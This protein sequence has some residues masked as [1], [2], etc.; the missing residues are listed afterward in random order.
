MPQSK[1]KNQ[2]LTN[3]LRTLTLLLLTAIALLWPS[4]TA[5]A[6]TLNWQLTQ[7]L[8]DMDAYYVPPFT[9]PVQY[10][11]TFNA[12]QP[13]PAAH[14][15]RLNIDY[16]AKTFKEFCQLIVLKIKASNVIDLN[17]QRKLKPN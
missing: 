2:T 10:T 7:T 13:H 16:R 15:R 5:H 11:G 3:T 8:P 9:Y 6:Q 1:I 17:N 12:P 14:I 4:T